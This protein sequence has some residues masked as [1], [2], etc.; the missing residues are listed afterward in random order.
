MVQWVKDL[1][2]ALVT[3]VVQ[4]PSLPRELVHDTGQPKTKKT[5]CILVFTQLLFKLYHRVKNRLC[6]I[7]QGTK[8]HYHY[9]GSHYGS[10]S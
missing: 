10:V 7:P 3:A 6:I 2:L 1:M 4:V 5:T 9:G 8:K